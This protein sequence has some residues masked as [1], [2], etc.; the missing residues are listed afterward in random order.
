MDV[1][2]T[3]HKV[4]LEESGAQLILKFIE[5]KVMGLISPAEGQKSA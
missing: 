3:H 1:H 5:T 4:I 2:L